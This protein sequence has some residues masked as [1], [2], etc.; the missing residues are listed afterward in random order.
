MLL[1]LV[2]LAFGVAIGRA[3]GG[4]VDAL[5]RLRFRA[6]PLVLAALAGQWAARHVAPSTR[7]GVV[8]ATYAAAAVWIALNVARRSWAL[9]VGLIV[10]ATGWALN[11]AV[12]VPNGGMPVSA[13]ALA[14]IH[15]P[16]HLVVSQGHLN[17]HV[18]AAPGATASWLGDDVAV[19]ALRAVVSV[20]DLFL[21]AGIALVVAAGMQDAGSH[22]RR[23]HGLALTPVS[24]RHSATRERTT[25]GVRRSVSSGTRSTIPRCS[26]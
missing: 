1:F 4:R 10:V 22:A 26:Q 20:G 6:A 18:L 5:G 14:A 21:A 17:K 8:A 23:R 9:R 19:P 24:S 11:L 7:F 12:M 25:S 15:A 13:S 3:R 16:A 2:P